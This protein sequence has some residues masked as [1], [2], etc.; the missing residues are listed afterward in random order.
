MPAVEETTTSRLGRR[1]RHGLRVL[2]TPR[3]W[4]E[5]IEYLRHGPGTAPATTAPAVS[6]PASPWRERPPGS[7]PY[8]NICGSIPVVFVGPRHV[9]GQLCPRCGSS[10][11]DRFSFFCFV[12]RTPRARWLRVL[13]T[14]P[15]LGDAYR[16]AMGQ[17]FTYTASDYDESSH[18]AAIRLDLQDIDQADGSF[19]VVLSAHV[20]EHVPDT[21]R[22]LAGLRRILAPG[23]R[24]YLQVP[25]QE[26]W[27]AEPAAPEYHQDN[28]K[29]FWRFGF[30]LA[31]RLRGHGFATTVLVTAPFAH[32]VR[33]GDR[34]LVGGEGSEWDVPA[35]VSGAKEAG[36]VS[37]LDQPEAERL[38]LWESYQ[39]AT[40]EALALPASAAG[41]ARVLARRAWRRIR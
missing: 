11:R 6:F 19:D 10:A 12:S 35:M 28:T 40:F 1:A 25:I 27:T 15:R 34:S 8:C 39:F 36:R 22:A 20:L 24:L 31:E 9:E 26:G 37:V 23:G 29:V 16:A 14:S 21:D 41:R 17:W 3:L 33:T 2:T 13:E 30:D 4:G 18:R 5:Q 32:A 38:G 7:E